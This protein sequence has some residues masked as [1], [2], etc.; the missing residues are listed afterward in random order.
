MRYLRVR[1][2]EAHVTADRQELHHLAGPDVRAGIQTRCGKL[3]LCEGVAEGCA[4]A[5][6]GWIDM[7]LAALE[8]HLY[9]EVR[10]GVRTQRTEEERHQQIAQQA[11]HGDSTVNLKE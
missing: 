2:V 6:A 10:L 3:S 4:L 8:T 5:A 7:A 9:G 1:A 11:S